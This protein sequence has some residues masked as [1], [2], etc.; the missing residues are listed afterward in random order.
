MAAERV[1]SLLQPASECVEIVNLSIERQ[2]VTAIGGAHGLVPRGAEVQN[3]QPTMAQSQTRGGIHPRALII[4]PAMAQCRRHSLDNLLQLDHVAITR[5]TPK[6]GNPT[7]KNCYLSSC[8]AFASA[9]GTR[10]RP[11]LHQL[12]SFSSERIKKRESRGRV[13]SHADHLHS[14]RTPPSRTVSSDTMLAP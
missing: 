14:G 5:Q 13:Q 9:H 12:Q 4:R 7:H 6:S 10:P 11:A 1:T 8:T 2:H 3:R